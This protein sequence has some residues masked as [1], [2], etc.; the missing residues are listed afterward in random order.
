MHK[1]V[2]CLDFDLINQVK[3]QSISFRMALFEDD[4]ILTGSQEIKS[5]LDF[6]SPWTIAATGRE[7]RRKVT[8]LEYYLIRVK[9]TRSLSHYHL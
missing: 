7:K 5:L 4:A 3:L 1:C 9:I 8:K 2:L 6:I